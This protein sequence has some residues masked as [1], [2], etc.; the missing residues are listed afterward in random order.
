MLR[1]I[2]LAS[3]LMVALPLAAAVKVGDTAPDFTL[4]GSDGKDYKLSAQ[5]GKTV[6]LEWYN[7][8]CPYVRKHYDSKNMQT[9]QKDYTSKG[10]VWF[11]IVSSAKGKEG[12]VDQTGA[13][14]LRTE[15]GMNSTAFLMDDGGK[16]GKL[17][18]AKTTP[19]MYVIDKAGKLAYQGA[20]DDRP[21]A[22]A[23]SLTGAT[24]Y[25]SQAIMA[26][27]KGEPVKTASTAPYGCSV[28]Y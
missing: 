20:I 28:K 23:K 9:L 26:L 7:K 21:S 19:H 22:N 11:T 10:T 15:Q 4:K 8:D 27:E 16:V 18:E 13:A 24:N 2:L 1:K 6:V 25:I 12:Y 17:Y 3:M 14:S 5:K